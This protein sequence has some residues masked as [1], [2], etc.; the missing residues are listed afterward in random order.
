MVVTYN[1]YNSGRSRLS[2]NGG[3]GGGSHNDPE[4]KQAGAVS[5]TFLSALRASRLA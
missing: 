2:D 5:K 3:G 4:I 1:L